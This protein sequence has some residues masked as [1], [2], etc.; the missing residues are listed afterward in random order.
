[1]ERDYEEAPRACCA[2]RRSECDKAARACKNHAI[3]TEELLRFGTC[4]LPVDGAKI[5]SK[6]AAPRDAK[7][8][9]AK[10]LRQLGDVGSGL[11]SQRRSDDSSKTRYAAAGAHRLGNTSAES[12]TTRRTT[13]RPN[14]RKRRA[15][16]AAA[17]GATVRRA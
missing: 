8:L 6:A 11:P 5:G 14:T 2:L 9:Y 1:M 7:V 3:L 16:Q 4:L 12:G 17:R 13:G 10:G 15:K